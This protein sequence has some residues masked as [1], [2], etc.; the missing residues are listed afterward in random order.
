MDDGQLQKRLGEVARNAREGLGI[1]QAEVAA[2]AGLTAP[3]YG[4]IE[5]GG[6][7]PSVPSLR[8]VAIALGVPPDALLDMSPQELPTSAN[9]LSSETRKVLALL[10]TWPETK[11]RLA[12]E[13]LRV[14][15]PVQVPDE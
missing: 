8:R 2:R 11:V 10:R 1:T 6:M 14:L 3:V 5:R 7:M 4:R 15:E 13:L 12:V 9:D